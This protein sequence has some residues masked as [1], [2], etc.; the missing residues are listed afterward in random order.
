MSVGQ[1]RGCDALGH[2]FGDH[3]PGRVGVEPEIALYWQ[4][5]LYEANHHRFYKGYQEAILKVTCLP[6]L[7]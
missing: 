2:A 6:A 1:R 7:F 3:N 4:R 5:D